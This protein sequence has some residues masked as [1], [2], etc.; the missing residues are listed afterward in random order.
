MPS[1][2]EYDRAANLLDR[3]DDEEARQLLDM[4]IVDAD[5]DDWQFT[6]AE[7]LEFIES[8]DY[9]N[10]KRECSA[11]IKQEFCKVFEGPPLQWD[12]N[13]VVLIGAIGLGKS[14][15][16]SLIMTYV[17]HCLLC[18]RNPP[19]YFIDKGFEISPGS[20]LA[21]MNASLS[22][23]NAKKVV[24]TEVMNKI[25]GNR[26]F[27]RYY[28][29]DDRVKTEL[30]FDP[31]PD[32]NVDRLAALEDGRRFKNV[33][34]FPG[35]SSMTGAVGYSIFC[36]VMDEA[37]LYRTQHGD[38]LADMVFNAMDRRIESRFGDMGLRVVAGSPMYVGDFLER[39][40]NEA[41]I[42]DLNRTHVIRRPIW[43]RHHPDW[44]ELKRPV[45]H[46][47]LDNFEIV[48]DPKAYNPPGEKWLKVPDTP[49]YRRAFKLNVEGALRDLAAIPSA[50]IVRFFENLDLI[51]KYANDDREHPLNSDGDLI[52]D[53]VGNPNAMYAIHIDMALGGKQFRRLDQ[54]EIG[55]GR[56]REHD[57]AGFA[58]GHISDY[59]EDGEPIVTIDLMHS[60]QGQL[61]RTGPGGS[62]ERGAIRMEEIV[63]WIDALV[64]RG[65]KIGAVTLDGFQSAHL[66]QQ[67]EDR[68]FQVGYLSMDR[69]VGP[70]IDMKEL[71]LDQRLDYYPH[72]KF[73]EELKHLEKIAGKKIDHAPGAS[74]DIAD[75]VAGVTHTLLGLRGQVFPD[76]EVKVY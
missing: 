49:E 66:M 39:K 65:F 27:L 28:P 63:R 57:A 1:K 2:N 4:I 72:Q 30:I 56:D 48:V 73:I 61:N 35:S 69:S 8:R 60:I 70:Y 17:A 53:F 54:V 33:C 74:K 34:I 75:A 50:A 71:L 62:F 18:L 19:K 24:F 23:E 26:W 29:P 36:G 52:E 10:L 21:I 45:F 5:A 3:L 37:T 40:A 15:M 14:Y 7:P 67:L 46:V 64:K 41:A 58:V 38:D 32:K 12:T 47:N 55:S 13:L 42:D 68:G 22:K 59:N 25:A 31:T 76:F 9:C 44:F 20:K 51:E 11:V 16:L 6:P 43:D